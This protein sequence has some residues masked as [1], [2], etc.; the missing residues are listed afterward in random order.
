MKQ[1]RANGARGRPLTWCCEWVRA[2]AR[3]HS[4]SATPPLPAFSLG[5]PVVATV[6]RRDSHCAR[7]P[8]ACHTRSQCWR[9]GHR[10]SRRLA[11][12]LPREDGGAARAPPPRPRG[13]SLTT[14]P[15]GG[16]CFL[17]EVLSSEREENGPPAAR[18]RLPATPDGVLWAGHPC[19]QLLGVCLGG[20]L[21]GQ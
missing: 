17:K 12:L 6:A 7:V 8:R 11:P 5:K 20:L 9:R 2:P 15:G 10:E 13:G 19:S 1:A 21:A 4:S 18:A 14:R 16:D 3:A